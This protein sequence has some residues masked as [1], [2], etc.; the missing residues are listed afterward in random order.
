MNLRKVS[1]LAGQQSNIR[2]AENMSGEIRC[3][4]GDC[5]IVKEQ[6]GIGWSMRAGDGLVLRSNTRYRVIAN[7][8][9]KLAIC[10][11]LAVD[12]AS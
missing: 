1:L 11:K 3:I 10:S 4:E 9:L 2:V 12:A 5:R 6:L 8:R 7:S